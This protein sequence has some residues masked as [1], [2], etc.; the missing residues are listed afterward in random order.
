MSILAVSEYW[1]LILTACLTELMQRKA[2][3]LAILFHILYLIPSIDEPINFP[4]ADE[5]RYYTHR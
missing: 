4:Q 2:E 5:V 1:T 3:H